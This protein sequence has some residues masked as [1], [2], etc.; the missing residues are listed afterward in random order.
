MNW[1]RNRS[2]III[3]LATVSQ[4]LNSRKNNLLFLLHV[5]YQFGFYLCKQ[6]IHFFHVRKTIAMLRSYFKYLIEYRRNTFLYIRMM[7]IHYIVNQFRKG[8]I[9]KIETIVLF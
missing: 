4:L 5:M 9:A 3:Y 2:F 8:Q 1:F 6:D 7:N